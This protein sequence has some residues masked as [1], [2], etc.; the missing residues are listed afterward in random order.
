MRGP[1]KTSPIYDKL[2]RMGAVFGQRYGWER[3]NWFAP[4]GRRRRGPVEL[5]PLQ[6]LPACRPRGVETCGNTW[7]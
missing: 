7:A 3:A 6:L 2:K 1:A 4:A 5:P